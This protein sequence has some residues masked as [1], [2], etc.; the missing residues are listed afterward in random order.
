MM[1]V[2]ETGITRVN[3]ELATK[4]GVGAKINTKTKTGTRDDSYDQISSRSKEKDY[5]CDDDDI[6][7]SKMESTQNFAN[8]E[9]RERNCNRIYVNVFENPDKILDNI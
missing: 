6:F 7:H 8:N 2:L 4:T 3:I 1:I 5:L 9:S